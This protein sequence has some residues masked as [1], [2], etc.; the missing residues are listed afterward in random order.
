M[1]STRADENTTEFHVPMLINVPTIDGPR[2]YNLV[3]GI[4]HTGGASAGHYFSHLRWGGAFICVNDAH[5]IEF[6]PDNALRKSQLFL[7]VRADL[8]TEGAS[9]QDDQMFT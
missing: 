3:A 2:E 6:S 9:D 8:D 1:S 4:Q 5:E 7:F